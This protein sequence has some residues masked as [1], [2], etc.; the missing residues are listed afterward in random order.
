MRGVAAASRRTPNSNATE[1]FCTSPANAFNRYRDFARARINER[2]T[3]AV[4]RLG[5]VRSENRRAKQNLACDSRRRQGIRSNARC[6]RTE[7]VSP[8]TND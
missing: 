3:L 6:Q 1:S 5:I 7:L 4:S 8:I 2:D